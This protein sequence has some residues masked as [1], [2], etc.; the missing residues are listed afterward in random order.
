MASMAT[1]FTAT[2]FLLPIGLRR[3]YCSTSHFLKNP[4][5]FRSKSWYLSDP[6]WKNLDLF[7][8]TIALPVASFSEVFIFLTFNGRPTYHFSFLQQ[9]LVLFLYWVLTIL[10]LLHGNV[11]PLLVN[12]SFLF[13]CSGI[14]FFLENL[15]IGK[16]ISGLVSEVVYRLCGDLTIICGCCCLY[17][18]IKPSA[19]FIEFCLCC[20]LVLKGTWFLQAGLCLYTDVF[21]FKGCHKITVLMDN[22]NAVLKCDLEE[23]GLRGVALVNL[24]FIGHAIGVLLV[25]LGMFAILSSHRNSRHG[26]TSGPLLA[27]LESDSTLMRTPPEFELE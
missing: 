2:L 9:A 6:K 27:G 3:L 7:I 4:S 17:L 20:G 16:G 11:D 15:V 26:E 14:V 10:F 13:V 19:F 5:L 12:D 25:S 18:A 22:E 23:D 1:H 21:A 8:L 24:L